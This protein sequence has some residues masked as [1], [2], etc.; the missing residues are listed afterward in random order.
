M[1]KLFFTTAFAAPWRRRV[2]RRALAACCALLCAI[3]GVRADD[4]YVTFKLK[5][6]APLLITED[7][8]Q[9]LDLQR[10]QNY[11]KLTPELLER[12]AAEAAEQLRDILA[13]RGYFTPTVTHAM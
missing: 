3:G 2:L 9:S 5:L 1:F 12:L 6:D 8:R 11:D 10:W 4:P 13:T 7:L